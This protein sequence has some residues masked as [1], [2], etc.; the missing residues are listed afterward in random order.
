MIKLDTEPI[1]G[2][3]LSSASGR[4]RADVAERRTTTL[5]GHIAERDYARRPPLF[6]KHRQ[7]A[8]RMGPH[9]LDGLL[10]AVAEGKCQRLPATDLS[11]GGGWAVS[12]LGDRPDCDVPIGH[13]AANSSLLEHDKATHVDLPHHARN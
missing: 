13:N 10:D 2:L 11:Y 9:H 3:G 1:S 6:V 4:R 7:A 12:L 5:D 8:H